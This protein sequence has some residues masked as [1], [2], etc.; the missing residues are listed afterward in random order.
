MESLQAKDT[1]SILIVD[2]VPANLLALQAVLRP[3]G[4]PIVAARSGEEALRALLAEEFAVILLDVSMPDI[5]GFETARLIRDRNRTRGIPIIFLTAMSA[6]HQFV[7]RAYERGAVDYLTKPCDPD[8]L[9]AKVAVFVELYLMRR[10]LQDLAA[11][12]AR[13]AETEAARERLLLILMQ[14]PVAVSF[15]RGPDHVFELANRVCQQMVPQRPLIGRRFSD[16]FPEAAA[17]AIAQRLD[18]AYLEG[19]PQTDF[20]QRIEFVDTGGL[21]QARWLSYTLQ[22]FLDHDKHVDGIVGIVFDVTTEVQGRM[23]DDQRRRERER[24]LA[25]LQQALHVRDDFLMVASHELR[26]PMTSLQL[27]ASSVLRQLDKRGA[28]PLSPE[29]LEERIRTVKRQLDRLE[30]L[31]NTLLDVSRIG[32]GRLELQLERVS[33]TEVVHDVVSRFREE[34]KRHQAEIEIEFAPDIFGSWDRSRVDRIV[35][36]LVSNAIKYG[37]GKPIGIT[38]KRLNGQAELRVNDRGIGIALEMQDRIFDKFERAASQRNYGGLGLGLW[39]ARQLAEALQGTV[40][41]ESEIGKGSTFMVTLPLGDQ[42]LGAHR[43]D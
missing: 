10:R 4:Q 3:L 15:L 2:D 29:R 19:Q 13:R 33:L 25:E 12:E 9:R 40:S 1:A 38:L 11:V 16:V 7:M 17:S 23:H 18:R 26:T 21:T 37:Q 34:A 28:Q 36:N 8:I 43:A 32:A 6:N 31:I 35:T 22:P 30:H 27:T 42:S 20:A 39:I 24:L 41:V 14:M 5:D